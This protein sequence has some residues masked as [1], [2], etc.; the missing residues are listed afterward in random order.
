LG[1]K[2]HSSAFFLGIEVPGTACVEPAPARSPPSTQVVLNALFLPPWEY[3]GKRLPKMSK[4]FI[5]GQNVA[6][7][8]APPQ[9][10]L[11]SNYCYGW[12]DD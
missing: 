8:R 9:Q 4:T 10:E 1:F 11:V 12:E 3:Y 7:R 2:L 5:G 6:E